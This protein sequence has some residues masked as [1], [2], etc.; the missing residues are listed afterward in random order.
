M[1]ARVRVD[2]IGRILIPKQIQNLMDIGSDD[3]LVLDYNEET[4]TI[5]LTKDNNENIVYENFCLLEKQINDMSKN[6]NDEDKIL[7]LEN[8]RK[9]KELLGYP[10]IHCY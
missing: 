5:K 10:N 4:N 2:S 8:M 1:K 7:L 9:T 3:N 6:M